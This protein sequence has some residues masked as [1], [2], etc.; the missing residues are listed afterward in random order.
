[1]GKQRIRYIEEQ[2]KVCRE[3]Y[4]KLKNEIAAIDRKKKKQNKRHALDATNNS[5]SKSVYSNCGLTSSASSST[6]DDT[7]TMTP[8]ALKS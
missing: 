7:I 8:K 4:A 1:M 6:N 5:T 3:V 2:M